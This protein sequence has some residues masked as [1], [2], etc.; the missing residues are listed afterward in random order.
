MR[1]RCRLLSFDGVDM[2]SD[3]PAAYI[4]KVASAPKL[5]TRWDI[6]RRVYVAMHARTIMIAVLFL[7]R[8]PQRRTRQA[9]HGPFDGR[10]RVLGY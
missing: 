9:G 2:D 5:N 4:G 10:E 1:E 3:N 8:C 6:P 7:L